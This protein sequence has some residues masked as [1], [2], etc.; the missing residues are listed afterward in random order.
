MKRLL[1]ALLITIGGYSYSS[2]QISIRKEE[3][4][5]QPHSG[6]NYD[7]LSNFNLNLDIIAQEYKSQ[8]E[9]MNNISGQFKQ[10]IGQKIYILPLTEKKISF[11]KKWGSSEVKNDKLRGKYYTIEDFEYKIE[12]SYTGKCKLDKVI[13]KLKGDDG[14][15]CNWEVAYYSLDEALLVGYYEKLKATSV[16]NTFVYTGRAK[17]K[18]SQFIVEPLLDHSAVDLKTKQNFNLQV[19]EEWLCTDMQLVDDEIT[20][21]LY[22]IL[23]NSEG[24]EIKARI[25]NR[26][27]TKGE[28][29]ACFFSCFMDKKGFI[30]WKGLLEKKYGVEYSL[31]I[32]A[33]KVQIGMSDEMCLEAWGEPVSKNRTILNGK[34]TEQWVYKSNSFLYFDNGTLTAIQN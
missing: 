32:T 13:F 18:G 4:A 11:N 17:G 27:L 12:K 21:Q 3:P 26:F 6:E 20:M 24:K 7:S 2:A 14:K 5:I 15:K 16:G 8:D 28:M 29:N 23:S 30:A 34:E 31:L 9:V 33:K 22:A 10:Y 25:E 1:T 19:G